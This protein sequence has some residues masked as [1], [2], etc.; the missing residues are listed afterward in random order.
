MNLSKIAILNVKSSDYCCIISRISKSEAINV[1]RNIDLTELKRNI[2]Q[3][4][5]IAYKN[6]ERNFNIWR[7]WN[8]KNKFYRHKS[9]IFLKDVDIEKVLPSN[10][11]S[12]GEENYKY[13]IY[14]LYN[15]RKVKPLHLM[16]PKTSAYVKSYDRQ[17]NWVY[18]L[19][20]DDDLL[21]KY[22]AI[23]DKV[24]ADIKNNLTASLSAMKDFWKPK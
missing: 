19:N 9:P 4:F 14:Y 5:I 10:K 7:Y 17:T 1:L 16:L 12:F 18:F 20:K 6:A 13:F 22:N 15:D 11:I 3:K 8:W 2:K 21:E 24:S 23:W